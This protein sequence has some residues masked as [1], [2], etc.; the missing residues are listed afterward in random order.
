MNVQ[1]A[2]TLA[3]QVVL[4]LDSLAQVPVLHVHRLFALPDSQNCTEVGELPHE[5]CARFRA[6][7]E[8]ENRGWQQNVVLSGERRGNAQTRMFERLCRADS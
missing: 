3:R 1:V 6:N 2:C 7:C 5:L 4:G 8:L